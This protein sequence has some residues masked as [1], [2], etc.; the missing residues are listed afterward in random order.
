MVDAGHGGERQGGFPPLG[1]G[2]CRVSLRSDAA[3][4]GPFDLGNHVEGVGRPTV[5]GNQFGYQGDLPVD[6]L[7]FGEVPVAPECAELR[8]GHGVECAGRHL[9]SQPQPPKAG[10]Q[11]TG[12]FPGEGEG[13]CPTWILGSGEGPPGNPSGQHPGLS[14]PGAGQDGQRGGLGCYGS[15][16]S[17]V[18]A[19]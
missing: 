11:L 6:E 18:Q 19:D 10:P 15:V 16:L 13:E 17:F 14:R 2:L 3:G 4:L 7:R 5:P 1:L 9:V 8:V 12:C